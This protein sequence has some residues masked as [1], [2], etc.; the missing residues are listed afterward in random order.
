VVARVIQTAARQVGRLMVR[1]EGVIPR[2][3]IVANIQLGI[4]VGLGLIVAVAAAL[5]VA[6]LVGW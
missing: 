5:G 6:H 2:D 1:I 4:G 3:Q